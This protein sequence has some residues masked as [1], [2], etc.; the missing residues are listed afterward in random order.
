MVFS[1]LWC[2][3][4]YRGRI[5]RLG[6]LAADGA[7]ACTSYALY[8]LRKSDVFSWRFLFVVSFAPEP[9][10]AYPWYWFSWLGNLP[11]Q[12]KTGARNS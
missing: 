8:C 9:A 1:I 12:I 5:F 4:E 11:V 3:E 6:D 7:L 2:S 10:G